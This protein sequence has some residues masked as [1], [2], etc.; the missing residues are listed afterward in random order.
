MICITIHWLLA[1]KIEAWNGIVYVEVVGN[2][3][4][5]F[6]ARNDTERNT[7]SV[8]TYMCTVFDEHACTPT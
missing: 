3:V 8:I 4:E 1:E 7:V 5:L 2:I 6:F